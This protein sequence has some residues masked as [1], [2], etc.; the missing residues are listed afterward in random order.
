MVLIIPSQPD[1]YYFDIISN[2]I[3]LYNQNY[4][5]FTLVGDFNS[6][7]TEPH[8]AQFLYEHDF[9]NLVRHITCYKNPYNP[10]CIDLFITNNAKPL[11]KKP[12]PKKL[13]IEAIKSLMT[14]ISNWN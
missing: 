13:F 6:E 12:S 2:S 14:I 10:S 1:N 5:K 7:D 9:K 8:L 11:L 4:D 3:D